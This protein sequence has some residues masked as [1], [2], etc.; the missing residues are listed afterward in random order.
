MPIKTEMLPVEKAL[1][2]LHL[3]FC[4]TVAKRIVYVVLAAF[5]GLSRDEAAKRAG[6]C[7]KSARKHERMIASEDPSCLLSC[8]GSRTSAIDAHKE[9]IVGLVES[10]SYR[11]VRQI[12]S[13]IEKKYGISLS[14]ERA[15]AWLHRQG[16]KPLKCL[17]LPAKADPAEQL[18]FLKGLLEPL[19]RIA[20]RGEIRLGFMDASHFVHGCE[21]IGS[22]WC[23]TRKA[24]K[25]FSGRKR[26]SILAA[27]DFAS[28]ESHCI[29]T[30]ATVNAQTVIALLEKLAQ[31]EGPAWWLVLDNARCQHCHGA[32]LPPRH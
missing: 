1:E 27:I 11:T 16:F 17:S 4:K 15:M 8:K 9:G 13:E 22:V 19:I 24:V 29:A 31:S 14:C 23:K 7:L 30:N 21:H 18:C 20:N 6:I 12:S 5:G 3:V 26:H 2:L 32:A 28:K 25:A 10:G